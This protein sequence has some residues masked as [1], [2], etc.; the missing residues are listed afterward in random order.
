MTVGVVAAVV[1][2]ASGIAPGITQ[3]HDESP[4]T[5]PVFI[6]IPSTIKAVFYTVIVVLA[7]ARPIQSEGAGASHVPRR[8]FPWSPQ[9]HLRPTAAR[10][11][12]TRGPRGRGDAETRVQRVLLRCGGARVWMEERIGKRI[13]VERVEEALRTGATRLAVACPFCH[14][15]LDD[16]LKGTGRAE[17]I[18]VA[19]IATLLLE[20]LEHGEQNT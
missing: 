11:R 4:V 1:F 10:R 17:D 14:I 12:V 13:G 16:S 9:R 20:S 3:R 5:R 18:R 7:L 15:M 6:D 19:D 2:A 8:L